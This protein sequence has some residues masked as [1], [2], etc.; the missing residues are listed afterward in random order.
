MTCG[1]SCRYFFTH[2]LSYVMA[3][4]ALCLCDLLPCS[5]RIIHRRAIWIWTR[6]AKMLKNA[7]I[8]SCSLRQLQSNNGS[9]QTQIVVWKLH[10]VNFT[11]IGGND[12]Y[13]NSVCA[14]SSGLPGPWSPTRV[15]VWNLW[16]IRIL[17]YV[18]KYVLTIN[19]CT[20]EVGGKVLISNAVLTCF[21]YIQ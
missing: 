13:I 9:Y 15:V 16:G 11:C 14:P 8:M 18:W 1:L 3:I 10:V 6:N 20:W 7:N 12:L 17:H 21:N 5:F 19:T 2:N 4:D